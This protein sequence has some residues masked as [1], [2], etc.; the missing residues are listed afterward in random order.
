MIQK[1]KVS[2]DLSFSIVEKTGDEIPFSFTNSGRRWFFTYFFVKGCLLPGD[3]LMMDEP[4]NHMHPEAQVFIRN[5]IEELSKTNK[6]IL[7]THS[8][9]MISKNSFLYYVEMTKEGSSLISKDNTGIHEIAKSLGSYNDDT[10]IGD[11]LINNRLLPF[12]EIGR[13]IK[14]KTKEKGYTQR[15]IADKLGCDE[16]EIRNKFKGVHLTYH[17]IIWFCTN[18]ELNPVDIILSEKIG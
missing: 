14:V 18:Y 8:P 2:K 10:I 9:Y 17:D 3:I 13:R 11:I 16:R 7:T 4:A 1:V 15:S 12:D 6:V 5:D